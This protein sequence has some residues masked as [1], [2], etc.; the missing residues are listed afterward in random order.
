MTRGGLSS[1]MVTLK[2]QVT[3]ELEVPSA[4]AEQL[5]VVVPIENNDPEGGAQLTV[6]HPPDGVGE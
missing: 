2:E 6:A 5:T 4:E 3:V 1:T